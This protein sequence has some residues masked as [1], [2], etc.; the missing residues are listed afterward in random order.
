MDIDAEHTGAESTAPAAQDPAQRLQPGDR[1]VDRFVIVRFIARGGMGEVY[2]A[3]DLHLQGK[4][5]ALKTLRSELAGNPNVFS[6]S[7]VKFFSHVRFIIGTFARLTI[8]SAPMI[9]E[10]N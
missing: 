3:S 8:C 4:R 6:D 5:H 7:N 9:L 1:L 10:V 2:E